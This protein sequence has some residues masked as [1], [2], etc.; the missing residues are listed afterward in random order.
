[1]IL[2]AATGIILILNMQ[3]CVSPLTTTTEFGKKLIIL[4]IFNS[5]LYDGYFNEPS[6]KL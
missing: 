3:L 6:Y 5:D 4:I 1:M 2:I